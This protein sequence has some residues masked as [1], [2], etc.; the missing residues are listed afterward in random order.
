MISIS[1]KKN[2][3]LVFMMFALSL[4]LVCAGS[5]ADKAKCSNG[6]AVYNVNTGLGYSTIQSAIDAQQTVASHTISVKEGIYHESVV[7]TKSVSL[8]GE[9]RNNTVIVGN[10]GD[11]VVHVKASDTT[12][13]G[14]TIRD[15]YIGVYVVYSNDSLVTENI[16]SNTTDAIH[17]R[18]SDN[19][20]IHQNIVENNGQRGIFVTNSWNFTISDNC[21]C[22]NGWYGIN[23]NASVGGLIAGNNV[24][25]NYYDGIGLGSNC[26]NCIIARNNVK[27]NILYGVWF[28]SDSGGNSIYHNNI[29]D[30][31]IQAIA[32]LAN[33]WDDGIEGNY[34]GNHADTDLNYDGIGDA[35]QVLNE[36][37]IDNYPLVG[38]FFSLQTLA[39]HNI[40]VISNSTIDSLVFFEYN[41]TIKMLVSNMTAGQ[42]YGFCR[43][44]IP[45]GLMVEP[46]NVHVDDTD[47]DYVNYAL[48]HEGGDWWIYFSYRHSTLEV[49]IQGFPPPATTPPAVSIISPKSITYT[50]S[51]IILD[52]TVSEEPSW[53]SYS[54]NGQ[55]NTTINGN[56]TLSGLANGMHGIIV[57]ASDS[58]E[59]IGSSELVYFSVNVQQGE[60][61]PLLEIITIMTLIVV[62]ALVSAYLRKA[63]KKT[64]Q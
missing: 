34:W 14:F 21:V 58:A 25:R 62:V 30:N 19:C 45:H 31:G 50:T 61:F 52:F 8:I 29:A 6:Y 63:S 24:C 35:A 60:S 17:V 57:Y 46:Y 10:E 38:V 36:N 18:Y 43:V 47:P 48:Y 64:R 27:N 37:N 55:A 15:G 40:N 33:H 51:S 11:V 7:I 49:V 4:S 39:N 2:S 53:I 20:M 5:Y 44:R 32:T 59:N 41:H 3:V 26:S 42:T 1:M 13:K 28:D 22:D 12:I 54:L 23:A 9:N 16:L 56:I